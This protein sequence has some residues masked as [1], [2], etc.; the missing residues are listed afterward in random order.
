L[1]V[2]SAL[3]TGMALIATAIILKLLFQTYFQARVEAEL[4]VY[5]S[6][7]T[8][9]TS[10]NQPGD[11]SVAPLSD[12]RFEEPLSGYYWQ[13]TVDGQ[14]AFLSPSSWAGAIQT[15]HASLP[16]E[17]TFQSGHTT[18]GDHVLAAS[19]IVS[20]NSSD[21][22]QA[23]TMLV[24]IDQAQIDASVAGFTTNLS[25]SMAILGVFLIFASWA[26]VRVGLWPLEKVRTEVAT[27]TDTQRDRVSTDYPTELLPLVAGMN[28]L[29]DTQD[30]NLVR[31]RASAGD[32]AHGLKTPLT[33][34]QG[35]SRQLNKIDRSDI[36][37]EIDAQ[38]SAMQ[39]SVER[40]LARVRDG[41]ATDVWCQ[42]GPVVDRLV[43]SFKH[44][45]SDKPVTWK[46]QIDE[47]A[48]C[49]FD[50]FS[51]IELLGNLI[52]NALKWTSRTVAI[53]IEGSRDT[54]FIR[55]LDDGPGISTSDLEAATR[56]GVR[57]DSGVAGHGLGL[58]IVGDMA[59]Q[60]GAILSLENR[61]ESGLCVQVSW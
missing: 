31:A 12:P 14:S 19:W 37:G 56:R 6:Q 1:L 29:L 50:E 9:R 15:P 4:E 38:I 30:K 32:L 16:G 40:E 2:F 54:G 20:F 60:R 34:L 39:H 3:S 52:D 35:V 45:I 17:I 24:A 57:L 23:I 33:I 48:I 26:Q 51:L 49:P 11:I 46:V 55:V 18:A 22:D 53:E 36:A 61:V 25:I 10:I 41:N 27:I 7:L 58:A 42:A 21:G 13:L 28:E 44:R 8:D 5:L 47:G 59:S 43:Q